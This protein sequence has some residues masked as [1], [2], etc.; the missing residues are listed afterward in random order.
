M[1]VFQLLVISLFIG[2]GIAGWLVVRVTQASLGGLLFSLIHTFVVGFAIILY[3]CYRAYTET[4][5]PGEPKN[6]CVSSHSREARTR[7]SQDPIDD[8]R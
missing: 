5:E 7:I 6:H 1:R 3:F 2:S 8:G 4:P